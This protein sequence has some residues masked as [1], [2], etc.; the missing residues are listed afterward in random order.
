MET[1]FGFTTSDAVVVCSD[2]TSAQDIFVFDQ[3]ADKINEL[4]G[5]HLLVI[6]G[7]PGDRCSQTDFYIRSLHL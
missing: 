2:M 7:D 5:K 6:T 4:F 1:V 3:S